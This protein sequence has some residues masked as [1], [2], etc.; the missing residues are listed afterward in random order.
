MRIA[1]SKNGTKK[2]TTTPSVMVKR[3]MI[4]NIDKRTITLPNTRKSR[5]GI[6][7]NKINIL[8]LEILKNTIKSKV[9][10]LI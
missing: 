8:T 9:R 6:S 1:I 5:E 3:E 4:K 10:T 7:K 2:I